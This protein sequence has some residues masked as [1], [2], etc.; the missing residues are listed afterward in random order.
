MSSTLCREFE[1]ALGKKPFSSC[2]IYFAQSAIRKLWKR[3]VSQEWRKIVTFVHDTILYSMKSIQRSNLDHNHFII[4]LSD[5]RTRNNILICSRF[6]VMSCYSHQ[7]FASPRTRYTK[8]QWRSK[9]TLTWSLNLLSMHFSCT[10][11]VNAQSIRFTSQSRSRY[12]P[13][14]RFAECCWF[15]STILAIYEDCAASATDYTEII[16]ECER[17]I[18]K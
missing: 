7:R 3:H 18:N 11:R 17:I 9:R 8:P 12:Q 5:H 13:A 14:N 16:R 1:L 4:E 2:L 15:F 10:F 6:V